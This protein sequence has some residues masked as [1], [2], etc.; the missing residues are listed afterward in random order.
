MDSLRSIASCIGVTGTF[1]VARDFFGFLR[2]APSD[3]S[4]LTQIRRL[5]G[6]HVH[7]NFIRVGSD[8]FED[9]DLAEMDAALQFTRDTYAQVSLGVGRIEHFVI[10]TTDAD[11]AEN[12]GSDDDAE[13]LT[14]DWTVD[15]SALD[16]FWVLSYSGSTIG[17]SRVDGPCNKDA[18]GMD[19]SVVAIEG[20]LNQTGFVLAHEAAHYLGPG[21]SSSSSNLMFGTVPNGGALTSGQGSDMRDHCFTKSGC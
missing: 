4:L 5:Q 11:G 6:R 2:G 12:I 16:I 21:H 9:N 1:S 17:L 19:G 7:M 18:K 3:V 14:N 13:E 20:S 8:Q 10:S 15:N